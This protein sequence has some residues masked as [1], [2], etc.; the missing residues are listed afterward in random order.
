MKKNLL[1]LL[2]VLFSFSICSAQWGYNSLGMGA[3][4]YVEVPDNPNGSLDVPGAFT[5]E[6]WIYNFGFTNNQKVAGKLAADFVNGFIF[7]IEDLT[8]NMEVFDENGVNTSL[9]AG[10]VS[11]I[12]WTHVAGSYVVGGML[13]IFINGEKV[14]ETTA[15]AANVDF[16]SNPFRIGI[17]PWDVNALGYVGY[18][19]E[20]RYWQTALD[21]ATIRAWMH[22]D[23]TDDHPNYGELTLYHKYN[24][25]EGPDVFDS[26]DAGN[27]GVFS[28]TLGQSL[29]PYFL[30]FKG[31]FELLENDVQGVWNAKTSGNSD[32][33]TINALFVDTLEFDYSA[34]I[35]HSDADYT[36]GNKLSSGHYLMNR[37][38]QATVQGE[39]L[40]D[41]IFDLSPFNTASISDVVLLK[42]NTEVFVS[43]NYVT[44]D[45]DASAQTFTVSEE[46]LED[47]KFY[48]LGFALTE[49]SAE[50]QFQNLSALT[51]SPQPNNGSF[52]VEFDYLLKD[53]ELS[54]NDLNGKVVWTTQIETGQRFHFDLQ[55]VL[56]P[57]VYLLRAVDADGHSL[58]KKMMVE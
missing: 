52:W 49:T 41:L 22:K 45:Y 29:E 40:A 5:F 17:A 27:N 2:F 4:D 30:P 47:E 50:E 13:T 53:A 37:S 46:V 7:G 15:S 34:V 10:Y 54:V 48:S 56:V 28:P 3:V 33:M 26:S 14:G 42:H 6:A 18:I 58:T 57:G 9:K 31:D 43:G 21:E 38:W 16:N 23:V 8:V 32:I 51:I 24:E 35:G 44:G 12:G 19:D 55:G 20:V 36:F 1:P 25:S 11:P 39:F